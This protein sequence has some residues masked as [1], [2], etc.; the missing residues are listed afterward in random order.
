MS[1]CSKIS[2]ILAKVMKALGPILTIALVAFAAF[3]AFAGPWF[4]PALE[5]FLG[6]LPSAM[7]GLQATTW[8]YMALGAAVLVDSFTG[9]EVLG[10]IANGIGKVAGKVIA[11]VVGGVGVGIFGTGGFSTLFLYGSLGLLAYFLLTSDSKDEKKPEPPPV[12]PPPPPPP[13][14]TGSGT[15]RF[16]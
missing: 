7:I 9:G 5:G 15:M 10:S 12:S 11:G 4:I 2:E 8:A 3:C 14:P 1:C 13:E 16:T 6:F